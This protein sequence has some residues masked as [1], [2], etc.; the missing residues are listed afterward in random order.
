MTKLI[1]TPIDMTARGSFRERQRL[2][3]A[4]AAM[5][6]AT[7]SA[8][9]TGLAQAFEDFETLVTQHAATDD[10]STVAEALELASA[11]EFD[12]LLSALLAKAETVPN[13]SGAS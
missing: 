4:Y 2:L 7:G 9:V 3:R 5:Q 11:N 1:V 10:G 8:D 6:S 13:P 12:Q